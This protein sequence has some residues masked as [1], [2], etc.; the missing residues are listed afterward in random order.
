[1][2]G[3]AIGPST[4]Q[5]EV[6][7]R[8]IITDGGNKGEEP[9]EIED[10]ENGREFLDDMISG[11]VHENH[12]KICRIRN[13]FI[14]QKNHLRNE[15]FSPMDSAMEQSI[16]DQNPYIIA[17]E[18]LRE[19]LEKIHSI[20]N[21]TEVFLERPTSRSVD[22]TVKEVVV[23]YVENHAE[24]HSQRLFTNDRI[25]QKT[26]ERYMYTKVYRNKVQGDE[27]TLH[28]DDDAMMKSLKIYDVLTKNKL[29]ILRLVWAKNF[30]DNVNTRYWTD[31]RTGIQ[32]SGKTGRT[33]KRV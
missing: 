13:N 1:M 31:V 21:C 30:R 25:M 20:M 33:S 28:I 22:I 14:S 4:V 24:S 17:K 23:H 10:L 9:V 18:C 12:C 3:T 6:T 26:F 29:N 7:V 2:F 5:R 16:L 15:I 19:F 11:C 8:E 27:V 32:K